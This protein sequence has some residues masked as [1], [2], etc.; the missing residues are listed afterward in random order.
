M[1]RTIGVY[2]GEAGRRVGT[3]RF[4]SQGTRQSAALEYDREGLT[5]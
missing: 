2:P 5:A 4:D 3:L 1:K